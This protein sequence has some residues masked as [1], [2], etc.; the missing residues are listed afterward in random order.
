MTNTT[1][2]R[3]EYWTHLYNLIRNTRLS[4][5]DSVRVAD[6]ESQKY[7]DKWTA[8]LFDNDASESYNSIKRTSK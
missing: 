8:E 6:R 1:E 7:A 5:G 2:A 3:Q 4:L